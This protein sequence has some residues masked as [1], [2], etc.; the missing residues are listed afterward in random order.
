LSF[1]QVALSAA[2]VVAL[3]AAAVFALAARRERLARSADAGEIDALRED[4][5]RLRL[6]AASAQKAEAASEAKSRFLA[7]VSHEVRTPLN[8][9]LGMAGL[10]RSTGLDPE[11]ASYVDAIDSSGAALATLIEEILDFSKIEAGKIEIASQPLEL[12]ALIDG[13]VELLATRAHA[14]G[15]D[16]AAYAPL[17]TPAFVIGDVAR[18]RQILINL[19]GNAVK[20]T[21]IGGVG[22]TVT[23]QDGRLKFSVQDSGPGVPEDRRSA[24][25]G[26]FEQGDS[27]TTTRY[28]G[29]GLG[30]AISRRLVERMGGELT[31]APAPGGGSIFAFDIPLIASD[32]P[33]RAPTPQLEGRRAL[34]AAASRF[35]GPYLAQRL[36]ETGAQVL[37]APDAQTALDAMQCGRRFDVALIDCALGVETATKLAAAAKAAGARAYI[38]FSPLERRALGDVGAAGFD[39]W[40]VKPV[41]QGAMLE[42]LAERADDARAA[43]AARTFDG[44]AEGVEILLAEDNE[45]NAR[46]ALRQ[47]ERLGATVSHARDGVEALEF[48][49]AAL[50]GER[51]AFDLILMDIRM[52]GLDGL[53]ATRFLRVEEAR[54]GKAPTRVAA[55]TA[56]A[57]DED[58]QACRAAGFDDFL[59]K[60]LD[61]DALQRLV[62]ESRAEARR[63]PA[64]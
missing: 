3:V 27:S 51:P 57:F 45:I 41:R 39:G 29:A 58:K 14:K 38:L 26:E 43:T 7:T 20:F 35:E 18:L 54:A 19:A 47:L 37:G 17:S 33:A 4:L 30:L 5:R 13:V 59:T 48:A 55:L 36:A 21:D 50:R 44:G 40:L 31:Y 49:R 63:Q 53:E 24:I 15:L 22:L 46:I 34:V 64:A 12:T 61:L 62:R 10:L 2:L 8:G 16:I 42:R 32:E 52:P 1:A 25:F 6:A 11:Q 60:P 56:N 23:A 28:G 9:I